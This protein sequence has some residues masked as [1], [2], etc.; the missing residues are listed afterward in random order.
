MKR[1]VFRAALALA[2][3]LFTAACEQPAGTGRKERV[4]LRAATEVARIGKDAAYP[5]DGDYTLGADLTLDNWVPIGTYGA[6]FAGTFNGNGKTLT[7]N[8]SGGLFAFAGDAVIQNLSV[9]GTITKTGD[10]DVSVYVGGIVGFADNTAISSCVSTADIT[11]EGH[12]HNSSAGGIAGYL[13]FNS[14]IT[15]CSA[16]GTITLRSGADE[17]LMLYAGGIAGYQG[18][19]YAAAGSSDCVIS[20]SYFTGSVTTEGG[21]PYAGGIAGYNYCGSIIRECYSKDGTVTARGENIPYAGG[22]SGYNSRTAEGGSPAS[23]IENCHSSITVSA[24]ASSKQALAGGITAANAADAVVANCYALGAVSTVIDS[25]SDA[26]DGGSI[27]VPKAASAGGIAGAQYFKERVGPSIQNCAALNSAI[28]GSDLSGA[29]YNVR[30]I[31][32]PEN[33]VDEEGGAIED[34]TWEN[35]LANVAALVAGGSN[36]TPAPNAAGPDGANCAAKPNQAAYEAL[37]WDF[38][39]VWKM[40]GDGYPV[41]QWQQ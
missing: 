36:V 38:A 37:D 5:L 14:S 29:S 21:Y 28:T 39:S 35:N 13:R 6:R 15:G 12:G 2:A 1:P 32:G 10:S 17:G 22:I 3:L 27:G 34:R 4:T 25:G 19:G 33:S 8:G 26:A 11:V 24:Q 31:A 9:A 20:R 16:A 7:I 41:L 18:T 40:A 30:R 23:L